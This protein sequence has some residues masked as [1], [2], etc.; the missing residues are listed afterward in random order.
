V[1][2]S[3]AVDTTTRS[4]AQQITELL[5][6]HP[7][8][9]SPPAERAAW[10][11]HTVEQLD[12]DGQ[13]A[14]PSAVDA[15]TERSETSF[16]AKFVEPLTSD[17]DATPCPSWC[18]E[19]PHTV[20]LRTNDR[21][22]ESDHVSIPLRYHLGTEVSDGE[23]QLATAQVL[24]VKGWNSVEPSLRLRRFAAQLDDN[25]MGITKGSEYILSV[26]EATELAHVLLA[27]VDVATGVQE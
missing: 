2:T 14:T 4:Y 7:D 3:N 18:V 16:A 9:D 21:R 12:R 27:A 17:P 10:L 22:H 24:I 1:S 5:R 8:H 13:R 23:V 15:W 11:A 26:A 25:R 20:K 6:D 19:G